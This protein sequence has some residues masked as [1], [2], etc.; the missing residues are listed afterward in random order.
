MLKLLQASDMEMRADTYKY[1]EI[2]RVANEEAV[3]GVFLLGDFVYGGNYIR[4]AEE[5]D[6]RLN[7]ILRISER[8]AENLAI[9]ENIKKYGPD[10]LKE[11][12]SASGIPEQVKN[13]VR[14]VL[15]AYSERKPEI[16]AVLRK[17]EANNKIIIRARAKTLEDILKKSEQDF[18][19]IDNVLA[20]INADIY[21]VAGN[22]D[23]ANIYGVMQNIIFVE[24]QEEPIDFH[25][26][27]IAGAVNSYEQIVG[28]PEELFPHLGID[29]STSQA[30]QKI[31]EIGAE[32]FY[33]RN[34]EYQRLK[35]KK[36]DVLLM[37]KGVGSL[38]VEGDVNAD[39]GA[40]IARIVQEAKPKIILCGHLQKVGWKT[41]E[42]GF[43][44]IR[45]S[46]KKFYI[47]HID[48]SAKRIR[49][50]VPY[51]FV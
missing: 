44:G 38:A 21:G 11:F 40:G 29:P 12:L 9:Y 51:E 47:L 20:G 15:G 3:D 1:D 26:L 16:D 50:I 42:N 33:S 48:E 17:L 27:K 23:P 6:R 19:K 8:D 45:S 49:K 28:L 10:R 41:E 31:A 37:H 35:G 13:K 32:E 25:G 22:H 4:I 43:Q 36:I 18:K 30:K 5:G 7:D 46:E 39:Y 14:A 2:R 24:R 34:P